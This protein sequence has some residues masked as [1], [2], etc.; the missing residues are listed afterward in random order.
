MLDKQ[1][2]NINLRVEI[3]MILISTYFTSSKRSLNGFFSR[4]MWV[5][6]NQRIS[7]LI[8]ILETKGPQSKDVAPQKKKDDE[9]GGDIDSFLKSGEQQLLPAVINFIDKLDQ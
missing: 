2:D 9:D 7:E 5:T 8:Q 1:H 4:D 3:L 6:T